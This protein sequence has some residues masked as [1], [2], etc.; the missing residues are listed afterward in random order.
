MYTLGNYTAKFAR[1]RWCFWQ[2]W[3]QLLIKSILKTWRQ[4][5]TLCC[6]IYG[7]NCLLKARPNHTRT[8]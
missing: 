5:I 8:P 6:H 4:T 1:N 3:C 7:A 2:L